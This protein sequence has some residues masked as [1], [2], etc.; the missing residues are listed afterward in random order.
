MEEVSGFRAF[1]QCSCGAYRWYSTAIQK[2]ETQ[3]LACGAPFAQAKVCYWPKPHK[4][5]GG[6]RNRMPS[7]TVQRLPGQWPLGGWTWLGF[8]TKGSKNKGGK[9]KGNQM[10]PGGKGPSPLQAGLLTGSST[11]PGH[12]RTA[13]G[14]AQPNSNTINYSRASKD[15]L[16]RARTHYEVVRGLW[17]EEHEYTT[18]AKQLLES[19]EKEALEK[20]PPAKKLAS[21]RQEY[22]RALDALQQGLQRSDQL[23]EE[24]GRLQKEYYSV[25]A[26]VERT[27]RRIQDLQ[28]EI[29][30]HEVEL[31]QAVQPGEQKGLRDQLQALLFAHV[32]KGGKALSDRQQKRACDN[33][34]ELLKDFE[35]DGDEN[36]DG[37]DLDSSLPPLSDASEVE[38]R[39]PKQRRAKGKPSAGQDDSAVEDQEWQQGL[40]A[41]GKKLVRRGLL[42]KR[43]VQQM[44][45]RQSGDGGGKA[46]GKGKTGKG[47]GKYVSFSAAGQASQPASAGSTYAQ[48]AT[49]DQLSTSSATALPGAAVP[50]G[51]VP[52]GGSLTGGW[53]QLHPQGSSSVQ[54]VRPPQTVDAAGYAGH[55]AQLRRGEGQT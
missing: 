43:T 20:Q 4:A 50:P 26:E 19:A 25:D 32:N 12:G 39:E 51:G 15:A 13:A 6:G 24:M 42:A 30:S 17:G 45:A 9:G 22:N 38:E 54:G 53:P 48:A 49:K 37:S 41:I 36:M 18:A 1:Y 55:Q 14:A 40:G 44:A 8:D 52:E 33:L 46:K 28:V 11:V 5:G 10:G 16:Y 2:G 47:K 3:C 21:L 27:A 29:E 34:E 35:S 7:S 31:P 23:E